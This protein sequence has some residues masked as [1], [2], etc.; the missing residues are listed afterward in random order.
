MIPRYSHPEMARVWSDENKYECW[1]RVEV[2]VCEAWA[3][4]GIVPRDALPAI[5]AATFSLERIEQVFAETRHDVIAFVRSLAESAG[6]S[7]RYI[8][9]GLTSS[10]VW[11]TA[12]SLQLVEATDIL[13]DDLERV[14]AAVA[15]LAVEHRR[16]PCIGRSHGIHAEPT[17]FGHKLAV[18]VAMLRRDR[19][20][21]QQ[22]RT[23]IGVGKI[24]GAV[25]T[26]ANVPARVE[27][28]VCERLGLAVS[29]ASTQILQRDRH[30]AYVAVLAVVAATLEMMATELRALQRTE[31]GEVAE[32]FSAGQQGS[33]SMPHKRNPE[34]GERITGL[35]RVIRAAAVPALEDVALWH[36]RDI[37]HS[38]VERIIFPDATIGLDYMLRLF[39]TIIEGLQVFPERMRANIDLTHGLVFSERVLLKLVESGMAR[40]D[41]Y[42]IVQGT[43]RRVWAGE[44][45]LRTLLAKDSRVTERLTPEQLDDCFELEYHLRNVDVAFERLGLLPVGAEAH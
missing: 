41:A 39:A 24:S 28:V 23:E 12:T 13:A 17:T 26:H 34:L 43:A 14:E 9:F 38:S 16:T 3:E 4:Q 8:H 1:R 2:A 27:E 15:R 30:A 42:L 44:G 29:P 19:I 45:D 18:W 5:Q 40:N 7:G 32:P 22:A 20:R 35:A 36:E 33:S 37:S 25:G 11:D 21:L 6:P 31:V 10:D